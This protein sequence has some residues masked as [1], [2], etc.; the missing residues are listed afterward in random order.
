MAPFGEITDHRLG[1]MLDKRKNEGTPRPYLRNVNVRWHG[2]DLS[3]VKEMRVGDD[4]MDKYTVRR[5]D[6]VICEGGEPG[7]AAIWKRDGPMAYQKAV[8]RAR[9]H[10]GVQ[11]SYLLYFLEHAARSGQ[12]AK[13]FTGSTINHLT[14]RAL[15]EV[16]VPLAPADEQRR[17]VDAIESVFADLD[18]GVAALAEARAGL[19]RYRQSVLKAATEGALTADWRAAHPDAEPTSALLARVTDERRA[20]WEADQLAK[21]E[22]KGQTP[23]KNWQARYKPP[24]EPETE[25]L[26]DAP[27]G[28]AWASVDQLAAL[29]DRAITDGPFGS[30]LKTAHYTESGPRVIRLQNI[31]DGEFV[32]VHAHVSQDH[33]DTLDN[34]HIEGGDVVIASLGEELPRACIVPAS[35]GPALVKADCVRFKPN[36]DVVL[37]AYALFS[38]NAPPTRERTTG[39]IH[40][41]GRPRINLGKLRTVALPVPPLAEQV[42]IVEA[43]EER[44]SVT[45]AVAAEIDRQL[46][47]AERL[48]RPVLHRAFTGR[49]VPQDSTEPES[50]RLGDT[51]R[52]AGPQIRRA[53]GT[54]VHLDFGS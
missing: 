8:H 45:D 38:L 28:W 2:F 7:R 48:R 15:A 37:P 16:R 39:S 22:V 10:E 42:A 27:D 12:L 31:G 9:P 18:A 4:E 35:V 36:A 23:S 25:D 6:L 5:G 33:F 1:K 46:A 52:T 50:A 30:N 21:Y 26:P 51:A 17:I 19:D 49:L 13:H 34:H 3:D 32:D 53:T 20:Q 40:G 14:G 24:A 11:A 47:R 43:V 44:L 29:E 54:Q 41:V